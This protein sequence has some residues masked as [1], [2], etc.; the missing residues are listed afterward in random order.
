MPLWRLI[1]LRVVEILSTIVL[2]LFLFYNLAK[3]LY[4]RRSFTL[5]GKF[6]VGGLI[7]LVSD[8]FLNGQQYIFAWNSYAANAGSWARFTSFHRPG[9]PTRYTES[10]L[11]GPP[12][13]VYFCAGVAIVGCKLHAA[14]R[15]LFGPSLNN[16]AIFALVWVD[17]FVSDFVVENAIIS[18]THAYA[19]AKTYG[20]LTLWAGRV[21]QFPVYES[22]FVATLGTLFTWMRVQAGGCGEGLSPVE[23][24]YQRWRAGVG[25]RGRR[26]GESWLPGMVRGFAVI[27]FCS[28]ACVLCYHLPLNWLGVSGDCEADLPDYLMPGEWQGRERGKL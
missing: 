20:P 3:P 15:A 8:G 24:G 7:A 10:L 25:F 28:A 9:A 11:W 5:D 21:S 4:R 14:L 26:Y 6:V 18:T 1:S 13:Y 16:E 2:L 27:G 23:R 12:M 19:F 22:V 17:A